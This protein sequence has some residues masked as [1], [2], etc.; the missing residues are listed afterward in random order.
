[1]KSMNPQYENHKRIARGNRTFYS[2]MLD[3]IEANNPSKIFALSPNKLQE[4]LM[5]FMYELL[6]KNENKNN[7][8]HSLKENDDVNQAQIIV[9]HIVDDIQFMNSDAGYNAYI[10]FIRANTQ[11][12]QLTD[13]D[14][15]KKPQ[16]EPG[17][18]SI[19][20]DLYI[21]LLRPTYEV[22]HGGFEV[23]TTA[24]FPTLPFK[25]SN[26]ATTFKTKSKNRN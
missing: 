13:D 12:D 7:F 17:T 16:A 20:P 26:R 6:N 11:A 5:E 24:N 2:A 9:N 19:L 21:E 3:K 8:W 22:R 25:I 18:T 14:Y 10:D 23:H 4:S 1:M 15:L